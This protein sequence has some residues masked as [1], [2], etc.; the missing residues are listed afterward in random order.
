MNPAPP[1]ITA[2]LRVMFMLPL[3]LYC[4]PKGLQFLHHLFAAI[5]G[6]LGAQ[7]LDKFSN[8]LLERVLR[9]VSERLSRCGD[10]GIAMADVAGTVLCR[11]LGRDPTAELQGDPWTDRRDWY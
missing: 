7:P 5:H 4:K 11:D 10:V 8:A 3:C 6:L 2:V 1:K 9:F